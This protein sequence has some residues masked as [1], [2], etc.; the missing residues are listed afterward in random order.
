VVVGGIHWASRFLGLFGI[1]VGVLGVRLEVVGGLGGLAW[2]SCFAV[3][4]A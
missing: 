2:P 3:G 1:L 4:I